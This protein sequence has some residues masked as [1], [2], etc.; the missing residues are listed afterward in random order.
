M[1]ILVM[2]KNPVQT[3][4]YA[5]ATFYNNKNIDSGRV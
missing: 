2:N 4:P 5:D 3:V 1:N